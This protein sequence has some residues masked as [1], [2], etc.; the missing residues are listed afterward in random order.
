MNVASNELNEVLQVLADCRRLLLFDP[1][2]DEA[3]RLA[4][5]AMIY[6]ACGGRLL[7]ESNVKLQ[8][9]VDT[10]TA[11]YVVRSGERYIDFDGEG[12]EQRFVTR[13]GREPHWQPHDIRGAAS[14]RGAYYAWLRTL[15][16]I[17]AI[18]RG[19][20]DAQPIGCMLD[21]RENARPIP[22]T[23]ISGIAKLDVFV[24][25][26][27][28]NLA[29]ADITRLALA[30]PAIWVHASRVSQRAPQENLLALSAAIPGVLQGD[31]ILTRVVTEIGDA[32]LL[33]GLLSNGMPLT[34]SAAC[35]R[36]LLWPEDMLA[37]LQRHG[38]DLVYVDAVVPTLRMRFPDGDE[39]IQARTWRMRL[40]QE[41]PECLSDDDRLNLFRDMVCCRGDTDAGRALLPL[42]DT[43][44]ERGRESL[45]GHV[46][47]QPAVTWLPVTVPFMAEND[48]PPTG[49]WW[50]PDSIQ[51]LYLSAVRQQALEV[52]M[53]TL[54]AGVRPQRL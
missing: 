53:N 52:D 17:V 24:R 49:I 43:Q 30:F 42:L 32:S 14:G 20:A 29:P 11:T 34:C 35:A 9:L 40:I 41:R 51:L 6:R 39:G 16:D 36:S 10:A 2:A 3:Q 31:A 19:L 54:P 27:M 48:L 23:D 38:H 18:Q 21:G 45:W 15:F 37:V 5:A 33:D 7:R 44:S 28:E 50:M 12:A 13:H 1:A 26:A 4:V 46:Y 25:Y 47:C 22:L 8:V